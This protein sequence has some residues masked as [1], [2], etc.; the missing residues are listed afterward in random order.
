MKRFLLIASII[1]INAPAYTQEYKIYTKQTDPFSRSFVQLLNAA[2]TRFKELKGDSIRSTWLMGDDYKLNLPIEGSHTAV[3]RI[4]DWDTNVYVEFRGYKDLD[5]VSKGIRELVDKMQKALGDQ[6]EKPRFYGNMTSLNIK[7][8]KGFFSSNIEVFAGSSAA[9]PYLL[10]PEKEPNDGTPKKYFILL[11]VYAGI[12]HYQYYIPNNIAPPDKA[13]HQ[14]L[15][16]LVKEAATDFEALPPVAHA[17]PSAKKKKTDTILINGYTVYVSKRGQNYSTS[18]AIDQNKFSLADCH[19][20]LQ[21]A[22]GNRYVFQESDLMERKYTFYY[23]PHDN[24]MP[25]AVFLEHPRDNS[26]KIIIRIQSRH[27]HETKRS[28]DIDEE[29]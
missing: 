27:G 15:K 22:L 24:N 10:G 20:A 8:Q 11:K 5:A 6:M 16:Q 12:P 21:A 2:S 9:E 3:V 18:L 19:Q 4:R 7:D 17:D 29:R 28:A 26:D 23:V 1:F 14:T 13:L 25:P